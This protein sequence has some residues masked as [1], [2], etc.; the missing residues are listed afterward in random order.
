MAESSSPRPALPGWVQTLG[1]LGLKIF[2]PP[3]A[4]I[5]SALLCGAVIYGMDV[6]VRPMEEVLRSEKQ[7]AREAGVRLMEQERLMPE[8]KAQDQQAGLRRIRGKTVNSNEGLTEIVRS[9][10]TL[11]RREGWQATV[12]PEN[13][14]PLSPNVP[15]LKVHRVQVE[16]SVPPEFSVAQEESDQT[17]LLRLLRKIAET[18]SAHQLVGAEILSSPKQGFSARLTYHFY[19]V[20]RG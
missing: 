14:E 19:R 17:R 8:E 15:Y 3:Y 2:V 18:P 6:W 4:Q 1:K 13:A 20:D 12:T 7:A 16:L 10:A 5:A 9:L 11:V